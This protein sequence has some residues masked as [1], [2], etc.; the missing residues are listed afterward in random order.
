MRNVSHITIGMFLICVILCHSALGL[1]RAENL[2]FGRIT[3]EDG[4]PSATVLSVLQDQARFHMVCHRRWP[5]P[6]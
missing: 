5:E 2:R 1:E 6:I 4:L 3:V